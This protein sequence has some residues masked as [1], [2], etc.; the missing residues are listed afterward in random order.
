MLRETGGRCNSHSSRA[1]NHTETFFLSSS[2]STNHMFRSWP[3]R[4]APYVSDL[5]LPQTNVMKT[6]PL[7]LTGP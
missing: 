4:T 5:A 1:A 3:C 6:G 2:T 7:L